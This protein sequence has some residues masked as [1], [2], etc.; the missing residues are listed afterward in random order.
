MPQ[1]V[2]DRLSDRDYF[3]RDRRFQPAPRI[4]LE[5]ARRFKVDPAEILHIGDDIDLDEKGARAAGCKAFVVDHDYNRIV[6]ILRL[7]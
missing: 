6:T 3:K 7:L 5:A 4:F 1:I 2:Q